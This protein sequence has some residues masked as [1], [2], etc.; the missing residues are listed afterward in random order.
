MTLKLCRRQAVSGSGSFVV[1]GF[2]LGGVDFFRKLIFAILRNRSF[3]VR[4]TTGYE[5]LKSGLAAR[6]L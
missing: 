1:V 6:G 5:T 3:G 4:K 2:R